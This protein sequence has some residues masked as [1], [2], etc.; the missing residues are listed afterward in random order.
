VVIELM[1]EDLALGIHCFVVRLD[2]QLVVSQLNSVYSI[3]HPFLFCKYLRVSLLEKA[4]DFIYYEHISR[5]FNSLDDLLDTYV[6]D[7]HLL[8]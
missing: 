5:E 8:H 4:L 6:L 2:S 7:W 3:F 1:F